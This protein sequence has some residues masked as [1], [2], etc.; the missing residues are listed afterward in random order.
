MSLP[1]SFPAHRRFL[2]VHVLV[3]PAGLVL[4]AVIV[5]A[6]GLDDRLAAAFFDPA[7]VGFPARQWTLLEL[8]GH[9]VAKSAA[10]GVWLLL[11][12]LAAASAFV[13]R[14]RAHGALLWTSVAAMAMGPVLVVMLKGINSHHCPWDL[15]RFGGYAQATSDWFVRRIEA[16][17]CFPSGHAAA[18]FCLIAVYFAGVALGRPSLARAG[19]LAAITAG[20]IFS[21][22]RMVQGAHFLSHNLWSAA[23][24]WCAAAF[25][26]APLLLARQRAEDAR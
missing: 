6:T 4:V 13:P 1:L 5:R 7:S 8:L 19:L 22:V 26:F 14:L 9:R 24:A 18:G 10:W 15:A 17:Q 16:G 23:I 20:C 11:L 25:T 3:I 2:L 12:T 21:A